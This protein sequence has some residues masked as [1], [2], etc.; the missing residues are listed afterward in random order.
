MCILQF[1]LWGTFSLNL[2]TVW[3]YCERGRYRH[4]TAAS[5][6]N[7]SQLLLTAMQIYV[8]FKGQTDLQEALLC[9]CFFCCMTLPPPCLKRGV[10]NPESVVMPHATHGKELSY[11]TI[12]AVSPTCAESVCALS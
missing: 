4:L 12:T 2:H 3:Y 5:V 8:V 7:F 9:C 1:F 6:Q 10:G 11:L